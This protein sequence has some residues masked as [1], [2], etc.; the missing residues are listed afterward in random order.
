MLE[1]LW[2]AC[3]QPWESLTPS[4]RLNSAIESSHAKGRCVHEGARPWVHCPESRGGPRS[5]ASWGH[6]TS[7]GCRSGLTPTG[8]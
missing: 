7:P 1:W 2:A 3:H 4:P 8:D 6:W 5:Q